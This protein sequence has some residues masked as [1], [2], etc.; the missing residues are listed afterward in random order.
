M[1]DTVKI[2]SELSELPESLQKLTTQSITTRSSQS[3]CPADS[4]DC[5]KDGASCTSDGVCSSDGTIT[6][7][8]I[9]IYEVTAYD[10]TFKVSNL[11]RG[12]KV[13]FYVIQQNPIVNIEYAETVYT[14]AGSTLKATFDGLQPNKEYAYNFVVN[15]SVQLSSARYFTT[16]ASSRPNDWSWRSAVESGAKIALTATE[17]NDF[18]SRINEFRSYKKISSYSFTTVSKGTVISA[19]IVN[20]ARTAI[21]GI[22]GHGTLPGAAASGDTITASFFN[23][24]VSALNYIS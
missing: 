12:D 15:G 14:A 18:C 24:L 2:L 6:N 10:V 19:T 5:T 1:T 9:S 22:S 4:S 13:A 16:P 11:S 20:Q 21:G 3:S 23:S 7:P 8:S 17:W